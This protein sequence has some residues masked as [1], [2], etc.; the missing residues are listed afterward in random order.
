MTTVLGCEAHVLCARQSAHGFRRVDCLVRSY[1][2]YRPGALVLAGSGRRLATQQRA[3]GYRKLGTAR[4]RWQ[5]GLLRPGEVR[6]R[7]TSGKAAATPG[8]GDQR[9]SQS[10]GC[11]G[12]P[13]AEHAARTGAG[14]LLAL[15]SWCGTCCDAR[16]P[17]NER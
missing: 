9:A 13:W 7:V 16:S 5:R 15:E 17:S 6:P 3:L 14:T 12:S 8:A 4:Q 1:Q 11:V 10:G 2:G